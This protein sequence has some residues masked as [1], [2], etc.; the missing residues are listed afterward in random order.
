MKTSPEHRSTM[1]LLKSF[2]AMIPNYKTPLLILLLFALSHVTMAQRTELKRAQNLIENQ[3]YFQALEYLNAAV[4]KG[5]DNKDVKLQIARC[6][7]RLK[8]I[9]AAFDIYLSMEEDLKEEEDIRYYASCYQ[10]IGAYE[11][12]EQWYEQAKK[13]GAN[14]LDMNEMIKAC[15]WAEEN[16]D[17]NPEV[18]VSPE[19]T[20]LIGGQ[21]FGIQF[22]KDQVVF[23][24]EK[25]GGSKKLDNTGKGFLNLFSSKYEDGQIQEGSQSF[26]ESLEYD[27]HVGATAFTSDYK[28]IY[29]T[30]VVKIKG[31]SRIKIFTS[32]HNGEDWVNELELSINSNDF[33][34]GYPA[35]SPDN[36]LLF[37]TSSQRGG[38][39]G[40]D[41]Y[42][43]PIRANGDVGRAENLGRAINTFG[44]EKWPFISKDG[45]LYFAS[46]GHIGF[47]GLDIFKAELVDGKY[48]NVTNMRRP[49]NTGRDDFGFVLDPN[50]SS[51]GFLSSNNLGTG[52]TDAIFIM[53][54]A[55][56]TAEET[57]KDVP[58]V[59][60]AIP[61]FDDSAQDQNVEPEAVVPVVTQPERDLSMFPAAFATKLTSTFK[62]A[63]IEGASVV[64]KDANTGEVVASGTSASDGKVSIV[65]ADK[66]RNDQQEFEIELSKGDD[67]NSKRMIVHIM[68]IEDIKNNGL[69]LTPIFDNASYNEIGEIVIA[70]KGGQLSEE[71]KKQ[72]DK[73]AA[74]LQQNPN[75]VIKLNGHTEA[76]GNKY[77]NLDISQSIAE[78]AEKYLM[79]KGV[80]DD[81]VIPRGYGERYLLNK[82]KRGIY[83]DESEHLKNRRIEVVVWKKLN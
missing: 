81:N 36:K 61:V 62:G 20:L 13:E 27:F 7:Y 75:V 39:G 24:G 33:D 37:F 82:C 38:L 45:T 78:A 42:K 16:Q 71:G 18:R 26:S 77:K 76:K 11:L 55:N 80:N 9:Q 52:S 22:Y 46:D 69:S 56:E 58:P 29:Y 14:P 53:T 12:A 40:Q 66:Y 30:K 73:L 43:A 70:Y 54:P 31:G 63:P 65:I 49:I 48:T 6:N 44:N 5:A 79:M 1:L 8:N 41:I 10:A 3:D 25:V 21:S 59:V 50:D 4:A 32:E 2:L 74:F 35:V 68:E 28:R 47:G 57:K 72:L 15:Q 17:L 19:T 23:S 64:I 83:C 60:D 51:R 67:F 34:I